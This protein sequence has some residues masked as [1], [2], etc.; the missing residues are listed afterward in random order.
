M[1][2]FITGR[3]RVS[4]L[5]SGNNNAYITNAPNLLVQD[6]STMDCP[7]PGLLRLAGFA[8]DIDCI[9]DSSYLGIR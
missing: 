2:F 7:R 1:Q 3:N 5:T 4:G 8:A 9:L 6:N